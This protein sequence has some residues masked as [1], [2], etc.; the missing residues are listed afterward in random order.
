VLPV[1]V[2]ALSDFHEF[3]G[4]LLAFFSL[5]RLGV[6]VADVFIIVINKFSYL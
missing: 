6:V 3:H 2:R 4:I 1:F 5:I